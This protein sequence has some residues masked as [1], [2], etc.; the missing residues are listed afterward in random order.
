MTG[1]E[2]STTA[3]EQGRGPGAALDAFIARWGASAGAERANYQLFL[4]ELCDVLGVPRPEPSVA[5]EAANAY[6]FDKAVAFRAPDGKT[7]TGYIDLYRRGAFVCETKQSVARE[8]RDPLSLADPA[9]P[10]ARRKSGTSVRGTAGWDDSMIAARGQAEGYVRALADDNPPFLLVIDIGHSFELYADFSRLGKVYAAFPDARSHRFSLDDL[11]DEVIRQRLTTLWLDPLALDPARHSAKVTRDIAARIAVLARRLEAKHYEPEQVA[12]FL[13]RCLFTFFSEDVCLTPRGGFTSLLESLK[14]SPE[15][16]V[17]LVGEVWKTMG[18][19]GFSTALRTRIKQFKGSIFREH[20][21]LPLD[22]EEIALLIDA[23]KSDWKD[24]EPAIFGT[25][26]ERA[27]DARERHKLGAHFTPRAYVER[28]VVPTIIEQVRDDWEA[29]RAASLAEANAGRLDQARAEARKFLD[30]LTATR[31][32]DPACGTGN[33][34]YV[35]MVKLKEIEAEAR[36]WLAQL[37]E[38][39]GDLEHMERT[40][41]PQQF[42]GIEINPRAVAIAEVVLWIGWL[43]WHLRDRKSPESFSEP[44]LQAYGNIECRD[45]L[46]EYDT[47]ELQRDD[48]GKPVTR[49]DGVTTKKHPVTGEDVPDDTARVAVERYVN[50]RKAEWPKAD[51]VVGNPPF[52]GNKRMRAVLGDDYTATLRATYD[53]VP[54]TADYVM[55][56]WDKAARLTRAGELQRFGLITTNS[57]TQTFNRKVVSEHVDASVG[58]LGIAFAIPDHPWVESAEGAA[59]RVAMTAG[60]ASAIEGRLIEVIE[61]C[62][63]EEDATSLLRDKAFGRITADLSSGTSAAA[64]ECVPLT[65]NR[66]LCFQGCKLAG[67]GFL[68]DG[69]TREKLLRDNSNAA[70]FVRILV[71]GS[72]ITKTPERRFV[73]DLFGLSEDE[74]RRRFPAGLQVAHDRVKPERDQNKRDSYRLNWWIFAEPRPK[75]RRACEGL[76]RFIGT[77]E[78]AKHRVFV[79]FDLP[80][81]LADGSLAAIAMDD[82]YVLGV[83]SSRGHV[84]WSLTTGGRMGIGNDPRYQNGPCFLP[85]PFPVATDAQQQKIRELGEAL[86][87]HRKAQQAAHPGLTITGMYNV[88]E[89]LRTGEPL[90][91]KEKKIHDDGL[92]S[93]LKKIH[94]DL[95]AAVFDAYGWPATL[96]GDE[97]LERLVALNHERAEEEKRGLV[98]WLRPEFQNKA[99]AGDV[100]LAIDAGAGDD[101][102]TADANEPAAKPAKRGRG[103]AKKSAA[104]GAKAATP[105]EEPAN[106]KKSAKAA[107]Q[108]WPKDLAEQTRAVRGVLAA[109]GEVV[110]AA[111]VARAFK[112]AKAPRVE[113]ILDTLVALGHARRTDS[114]YAPA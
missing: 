104:R 89:K 50:P 82:G 107:K 54:E 5:D 56:W 9:A 76:R 52:V 103:A 13:I 8:T 34:L 85:F 60:A 81:C 1:S 14:E 64:S 10:K 19:G 32:L 112:H 15:Q 49:W 4:A 27:L 7:S 53:D 111:D 93:V 40:V 94:D 20:E 75:M 78:V 72:D 65:A 26:L 44:I 51:F 97:I 88:L 101:D 102:D 68:I 41:D 84:K 99:G 71:A 12:W 30:S 79:F 106:P 55:Y 24:V 86:D 2:R 46:L 22:S 92:V 108:A 69:P 70:G 33:F 80:E 61:E 17:P 57:I 63:T 29:A 21:P 87:A 3:A 105:A 74:A 58:P 23:G 25:L 42:L 6:V 31:V 59:V 110:T 95:D 100:Q 113:E 90:T 67:K 37:G 91:A 38:T 66:E 35:S 43:Q 47:K 18:Q 36:D 28:L 77:S 45:A 48:A 39:Q 11:R 96:S 62:G 83:L 114:G 98:R 73:V 109:A 16:F